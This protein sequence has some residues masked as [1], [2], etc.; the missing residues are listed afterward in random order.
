MSNVTLRMQHVTHVNES[1]HGRTILVVTHP[2]LLHNMSNVT[3]MSN[4]SH[5]WMQYVTLMNEACHGRAFLVALHP[6]F[7]FDVMCLE[8]W[9]I[10]IEIYVCDMTKCKCVTWPI[11]LKIRKLLIVSKEF[12]QF[13]RIWREWVLPHARMSNVTHVNEA[14]QT[15]TWVCHAYE[16]VMSHL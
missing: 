16:W 7:V 10:H 11:L 8:T 13:C 3:L 4:V 5:I 2:I 6:I 14:C 1:C 12:C 15:H 9:L